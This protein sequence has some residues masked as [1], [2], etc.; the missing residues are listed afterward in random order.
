[1]CLCASLST[2]NEQ[3]RYLVAL[4]GRPLGTGVV[5][6]IIALLSMHVAPGEHTE[7][8]TF[9]LIDSPAFSLVLGHSWL[10]RRKPQVDWGQRGDVILHWGPQCMAH[11][12]ARSSATSGGND[13]GEEDG[14]NSEEEGRG[15][16]STGRGASQSSEDREESLEWDSL[17]DWAPPVDESYEEEFTESEFMGGSMPRDSGDLEKERVIGAFTFSLT[18]NVPSDYTDLAEVF[19]KQRAT[20]LPPHCPYNCAIELHPGTVPPRG[21]LYSLSAPERAAMREYIAEA[22]S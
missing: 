6:T 7:H 10:V 14:V 3:P 22:L 5:D 16:E 18:G 1:M 11:C 4:D 21:S 8:I 13:S 20:T 15:L 9:F 17:A 12:R 2:N 19:S